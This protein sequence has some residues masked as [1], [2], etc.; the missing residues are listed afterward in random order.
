M[1]KCVVCNQPVVN[2]EDMVYYVH[3][4]EC[5][6]KVEELS[7]TSTNTGSPKF[8]PCSICAAGK[9]CHAG[10]EQDTYMCYDAWRQ[11]RAG[12]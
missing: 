2:C 1:K 5:A 3:A 11:L 12:A 6:S 7:T 9:F 8:T 10:I 4:G